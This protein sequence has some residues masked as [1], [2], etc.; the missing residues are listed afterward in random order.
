[1]KKISYF[2]RLLLCA[3]ICTALMG[4]YFSPEVRSILE[5]PSIYYLHPG[6]DKVL[7]NL[8]KENVSLSGENVQVRSSSDESLSDYGVTLEGV[9]GGEA[10][11]TLKFLGI[12]V[13]TVTLR[14]TDGRTVI[15]GGQSIG[16]RLYTK[17]TLVVGLSD[18]VSQ[19][20]SAD[21]PA[22]QAGIRAGDVILAVNGTEVESSDHLSALINQSE[23]SVRLLVSSGGTEKTVTVHPRT[24]V[25]DGMRR[26][27]LWS[28]D[29]TAGVGTV[30]FFDPSSGVFGA[31]G[32]AITD[33]DTHTNLLLDHGDIVQ[34]SIIDIQPGEKGSP[35]ELKGVFTSGQAIGSILKNTDFGIYGSCAFMEN[36]SYP[37]G[38][39]IAS[40]EEAVLGPAQILTTIDDSGIRSFDCEIIRL[41]PQDYSSPR[42]IVVQVTDPV[43]LQKTGGIVQGMSGSPILQ[44]GKLIGAVTHVF[45]NDPTKGYG[46]Y[47]E[48]MMEQTW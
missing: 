37:G 29:S 34:S 7:P 28:R 4:A 43:L 9:A 31:L 36:S 40:R 2:C 48:W 33:I 6:Q 11:M 26:I 38:V 13:K 14:V 3:C 44:N 21:S 27:G 17:G 8:T 47:I 24:D 35:G 42:G 41:T 39:T 32:H 20:G 15:P 23:G 30:T 5:L 1:M 18:V 16:V 22:Q 25:Q 46:L 45:I 10:D 19:D 12:P